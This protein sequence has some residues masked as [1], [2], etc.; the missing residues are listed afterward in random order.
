[1]AFINREVIISLVENRMR[2]RAEA[3]RAL[4]TLI[5]N[6]KAEYWQNV[7]DDMADFL[8]DDVVNDQNRRFHPVTKADVLAMETRIEAIVALLEAPGAMDVIHK[9]SVRPPQV[10]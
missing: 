6:D 7:A 4:L 10:S 9:L 8:D 2:P 5:Q 1:M 3:I